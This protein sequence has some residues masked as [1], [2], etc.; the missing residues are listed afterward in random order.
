MRGRAW[1]RQNCDTVRAA[2]YV[3]DVT[4]VVVDHK[5]N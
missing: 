4:H 3:F 2:I 1:R 5:N